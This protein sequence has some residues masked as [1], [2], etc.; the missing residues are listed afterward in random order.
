[1]GEGLGGGRPPAAMIA[2][3]AARGGLSTRSNRE[4]RG[5]ALVEDGR[6]VLTLKGIEPKWLDGG[7]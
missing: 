2:A 1:M 5:L 3:M 4:G 6:E 7:D